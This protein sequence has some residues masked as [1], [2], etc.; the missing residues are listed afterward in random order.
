M[1]VLVRGVP[2]ELYERIQ[3]LAHDQNLSINQTMLQLIDFS[4][5]QIGRDE[6]REKQHKEA[7]KRIRELHQEVY[8]ARRKS[9]AP[10]EDSV[11]IIR[12]FRDTRN[13]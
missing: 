7:C 3:K 13:Q 9:S 4:L 1:N 8:Q 2:D 6:K 12:R 5:D 10:E 11:K